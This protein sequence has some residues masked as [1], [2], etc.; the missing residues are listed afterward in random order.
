MLGE[1]QGAGPCCLLVCEQ[2]RWRVSRR[3]RAGRV[4]SAEGDDLALPAVGPQK[5]YKQESDMEKKS[6]LLL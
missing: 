2:V 4:T 3:G 6:P 5:G 1:Q